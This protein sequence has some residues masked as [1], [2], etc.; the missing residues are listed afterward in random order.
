MNQSDSKCTKYLIKKRSK[1]CRSLFHLIY[2]DLHCYERLPTEMAQPSKKKV[3]FHSYENSELN[4]YPESFD[5][6]RCCEIRWS[7]FSELIDHIEHH[8][9]LYSYT[10]LNN[11]KVQKGEEPAK[12][13]KCAKCD[14]E[15]F[16]FHRVM[17]HFI[18]NHV[19]HLIMCVQCVVLHPEESYHEHIQ[20]CNVCELE[21]RK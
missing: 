7:R 3:V 12:K 1:L 6:W 21:S 15:F 10:V 17:M 16:S 13:Y 5:A 20:D 9:F 11:D 19:E 4:K 14:F 18:E 8:H 2:V